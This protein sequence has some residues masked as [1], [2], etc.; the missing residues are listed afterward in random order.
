[1]LLGNK[2]GGRA[3]DTGEKAW[4]GNRCC[5]G[6]RA[7]H[8]TDADSTFVYEVACQALSFGGRLLRC[9]ESPE[10]VANRDGSG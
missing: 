1:M 5:I 2:I 8:P 4:N 10:S 9:T 3:I 6:N 7:H